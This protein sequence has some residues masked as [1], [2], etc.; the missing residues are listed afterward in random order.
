MEGSQEEE[1]V[2]TEGGCD[3][4][5][6]GNAPNFKVLE[7]ESIDEWRRCL[8]NEIEKDYEVPQPT[9]QLYQ[10]LKKLWDNFNEHEMILAAKFDKFVDTSLSKAL[11]AN[12]KGKPPKNKQKKKKKEINVKTK[13]NRNQKGVV[14]CMHV[15]K[16]CSANAQ[17]SS[18]TSSSTTIWLI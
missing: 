18:R 10:E 3:P 16:I 1:M 15:A 14:I 12:Q 9:L 4:V 13:S 6:P 8:S 11:L 17:G 2:V 5:D 7:L